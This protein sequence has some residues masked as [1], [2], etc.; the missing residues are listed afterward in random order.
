MRELD[1]DSA[2]GTFWSL[3]I[4]GATVDGIVEAW[5]AAADEA[6]KDELHVEQRNGATWASFVF[7]SGQVRMT[8]C[9]CVLLVSERNFGIPHYLTAVTSASFG[10]NLGWMLHVRAGQAVCG[11]YWANPSFDDDARR[12]WEHGW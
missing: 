12:K 8:V 3:T 10:V 9:E 1:L 2:V 5:S 7:N 4:A 11:Q 6:W